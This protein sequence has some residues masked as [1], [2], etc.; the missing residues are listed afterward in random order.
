MCHKNIEGINYQ[1]LIVDETRR[2]TFL[3]ETSGN[4]KCTINS[5]LFLFLMRVRVHVNVEV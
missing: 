5:Y 2:L 4:F 3:Q 1:T